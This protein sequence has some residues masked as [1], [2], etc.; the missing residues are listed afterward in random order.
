M[1]EIITKDQIWFLSP[2]KNQSQLDGKHVVFG[3]VSKGYD[4][5]R[6]IESLGSNSG[7][8]S[9]KITIEECGVV[10]SEEDGKNS[11][12][13]LH[14]KKQEGLKSAVPSSDLAS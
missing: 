14:Q 8:T 6:A 4:V 2:P 3:E 7:K 11:S 5:V 12:S 1:L 10:G 13:W 9:K